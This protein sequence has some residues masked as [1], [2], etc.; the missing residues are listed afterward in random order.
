MVRQEELDFILRLM[1]LLVGLVF[2]VL[3]LGYVEINPHQAIV[4]Q[5]REDF[6]LLDKAAELA[7]GLAVDDTP[8][9]VL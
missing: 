4:G 5:G 7:G 6:P 2:Q 3:L 1:L 8:R 9:K